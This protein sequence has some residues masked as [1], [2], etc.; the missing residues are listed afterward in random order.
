M[1]CP[2]WPRIKDFPR[3]FSVKRFTMRRRR[4]R[5]V[6]AS[7]PWLNNDLNWRPVRIYSEISA[8]KCPLTQHL[9][10]KH[11]TSIGTGGSLILERV[12]ELTVKASILSRKEDLPV[13]A[14]ITMAVQDSPHHRLFFKR[15]HDEL[16]NH[17]IANECG[18]ILRLYSAP[19]EKRLIPWPARKPWEVIPVKWKP[20][21][22][23]CIRY[24]HGKMM[25]LIMLWYESALYQLTKMPSDIMIENGSTGIIRNCTDSVKVHRGAE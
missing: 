20:T 11:G 14:M 21:S 22:S 25:N 13:L 23:V 5:A 16:V 3:Q 18:H 9:K 4:K 6:S 15:D 12:S 24:I 7:S 2:D 10:G 8:E 1:G 17:V 19:E